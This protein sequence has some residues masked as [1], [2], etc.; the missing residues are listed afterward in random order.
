[1]PGTID[2]L[3]LPEDFTLAEYVVAKTG[4]TPRVYQV[5]ILDALG[6][7]R[8]ERV[9]WCGPNQCGKSKLWEWL[10]EFEIYKASDGDIGI[11][12]PVAELAEEKSEDLRQPILRREDL[13]RHLIGDPAK[14]KDGVFE[15]ANARKIS[16]KSA[17][18]DLISLDYRI[19]IAS[20][21][22][23][24]PTSDDEQSDE[25]IGRI[26][27][28]KKSTIKGR[29]NI[30]E[31]ENR[32]RTWISRGGKTVWEC[33]PT[34]ESYPAWTKFMSGSQGYYYLRCQGCN[35]LTIRSAD[36]GLLQFD[37]DPETGDPMEGTIVLP[38][39]ACGYQHHEDQAME[40]ARQGCYVHSV[41][42]RLPRRPSFQWGALAVPEVLRWIQIAESLVSGGY[43][44]SLERQKA[45]DNTVRGLPLQRRN[46]PKNE[47]L[48]L[49]AMS[50]D[51]QI[52]ET[53]RG[54]FMAIDTQDDRFKWTIRSMDDAGNCDH[55][56]AGFSKTTSE[57]VDLFN[58]SYGGFRPLLGFWDVGGHRHSEVMR[59]VS[60]LDGMLAYKGDAT[61][62]QYGTSPHF[63]I[64]K[65]NPKIILC[66]P[67]WYQAELLQH[68]YDQAKPATWEKGRQDTWTT[69]RKLPDTYHDEIECMR[70]GAGKFGHE[71]KNWSPKGGEQTPHDYFDAEKMWFAAADFANTMVDGAKFIG[72]RHPAY[73]LRLVATNAA[74]E[75]V[76]MR[77]FID[78]QRMRAKQA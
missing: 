34:L 71:Y 54:I 50:R 9:A 16:Y 4:M 46:K 22:D 33:T 48:V 44:G 67:F 11:M 69:A 20:E 5:P 64:S 66:N 29:D 52:S 1:M 57:I 2:I 25:G 49:S 60:S 74:A 18:A 27:A 30:S 55:I 45:L 63:K 32:V 73:W 7:N 61:S 28:A 75:N 47:S 24:W 72:G 65:N 42:M 51:W 77:T 13:R 36:V 39:P 3:K 43:S 10:V 56:K 37:R 15:F 35:E 53:T 6:D 76:S 38:C 58:A 26:A 8:A 21:V 70:S 41:T 23:R 59:V 62:V 40:M 14:I 17:G 12:F 78:R 31:M 68:I 19:M